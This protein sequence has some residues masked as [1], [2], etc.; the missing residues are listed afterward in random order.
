M[1]SR[2]DV[3]IL[4]Y[5]DVQARSAAHYPPYT[6]SMQLLESH[7][8]Y[9]HDSGRRCIGFD[10]LFSIMEGR[11][12][13][14]GREVLITFDD[15]YESFRTLVT[16]AL[17]ARGMTA[18]VFVVAGRVG[19]Y[20]SWD[21]DYKSGFD[22]RELMSGDGLKEVAAAGMY[23]GSHSWTHPD[24]N[25]CSEAEVGSELRRSRDALEELLGRAV[26]DFSYPFGTYSKRHFALLQSCGYRCAVS[27][28]SSE[29][30]VTSHPYA[31]RRVYVHAGDELVRFRLKLSRLYLRLLAFKKHPKAA[32]Q[33]LSEEAKAAT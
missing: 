1:M 32:P 22:R 29:K 31:M 30:Y 14:T 7:L 24:F 18:T 19:S 15:G 2:L 21:A 28:F 4:M 23:V 26:Q 33:L 3:P 20:N 8:D 6:V 17:A 9:L 25:R 13:P 16:P 10:E 11:E 27:I 12:A 5:H